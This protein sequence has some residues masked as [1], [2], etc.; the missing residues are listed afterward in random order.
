M[1]ARKAPWKP[2]GRL[3]LLLLLA[4]LLY[5]AYG[6]FRITGADVER[7]LRKELPVGT[8]GSAVEA[9]FA[10]HGIPHDR[11]RGNTIRATMVDAGGSPLLPMTYWIVINMDDS[12]AVRGIEVKESWRGP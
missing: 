9:Y 4:A 12:D 8:A 11:F 10:T 1:I 5:W 3:I 2:A 6:G 7:T